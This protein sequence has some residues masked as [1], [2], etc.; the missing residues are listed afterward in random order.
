MKVKELKRGGPYEGGDGNGVRHS[1]KRKK[2][3][4]EM[5]TCKVKTS[6]DIDINRF[7]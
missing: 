5:F 6:P 3:R 1:Q 7:C 2:G 4:G